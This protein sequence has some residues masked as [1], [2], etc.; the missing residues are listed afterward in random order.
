[1]QQYVPS[2]EIWLAAKS[3]FLT[4]AIWN[5]F[6]GAGGVRWRN[7]LWS[8]LLKG[9]LFRKHPSRLAVD[10]L[11]LNP[12]HPM[13]QKMVGAEISAPPFI[14]QLDHDETVMRSLLVLRRE[15]LIE[16]FRLEPEQKRMS[17]VRHKNDGMAGKVKFPDALIDM[18]GRENR[19]CLAL[20]LELTPKSPKRYRQM[21]DSLDA[22]KCVDKIVFVTRTKLIAGAIKSA[23]PD[24]YFS[25][26]E[27]PI[28]FVT[29]EDWT[30][31]PMTAAVVFEDETT[32]MEQ[33]SL[34]I[35]AQAA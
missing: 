32:S 34:E 3:G 4:K 12:K 5:D 13:V 20:E 14:A 29:I 17:G 7:L 9:G 2:R 22:L 23:M 6:F 21:M 15:R 28:G 25:Y 1:M 24:H 18:G 26:F 16:N 19:K 35:R 8:S 33:M 27:R 10:V 11:V 30:K 31:N